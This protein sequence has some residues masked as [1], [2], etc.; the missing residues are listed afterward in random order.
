MSLASLQRSKSSP[1][2]A[3]VEVVIAV[4]IMHGLVWLSTTNLMDG[5]VAC[6]AYSCMMAFYWAI[7]GL[8]WLGRIAEGRAL[9]RTI[10]STGWI[11]PAGHLTWLLG[12][13][14]R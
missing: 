9:A 12:V 11:A 8:L 13:F 14:W 1:V 3:V 5:G 10:T 7:V 2:P 6:I 4:A